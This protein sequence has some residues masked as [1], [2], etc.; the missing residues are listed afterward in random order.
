VRPFDLVELERAGAASTT[1]SDTPLTL[2]RSS[3]V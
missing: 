3:C 2:P 1:S